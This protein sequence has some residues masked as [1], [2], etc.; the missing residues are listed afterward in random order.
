MQTQEVIEGWRGV[1]VSMGLKHP[2]SRA[3]TAGVVAGGVC[4][5]SKYPSSAFQRDG[6]MRPHRALSADPSAT[7]R[8]FILTPLCVAI[9]VSLLT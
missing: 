9:A 5:L 7:D 3:I 6:S 1:A 8:H 2:I 4:Y